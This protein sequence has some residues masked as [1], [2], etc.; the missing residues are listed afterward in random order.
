[1]EKPEQQPFSDV[2]WEAFEDELLARAKEFA[3]R[4]AER[5]SRLTGDDRRG[6]NDPPGE[7]PVFG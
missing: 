7:V 1:M 6:P 4:V 5:V 2:E 3:R